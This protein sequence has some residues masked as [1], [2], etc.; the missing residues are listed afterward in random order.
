MPKPLFNATTMTK[1]KAERMNKKLRY[2]FNQ[3][4]SAAE[5]LNCEDLHHKK[6]QYHDSGFVCPAEY[7]LQRHINAVKEYLTENS[8]NLSKGKA[9]TSGH[10]GVSWN[11][12]T[13]KWQALIRVKA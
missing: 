11:K 1:M 12:A 13:G 9:N 5:T 10:V 6:S 7:E 3:V 8:K 4:I 2:S